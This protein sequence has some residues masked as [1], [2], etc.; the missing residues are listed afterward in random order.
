VIV[1]GTEPDGTPPRPS[2][3]IEAYREPVELDGD[4]HV[5]REALCLALRERAPLEV[6]GRRRYGA[7]SLATRSQDDPTVWHTC[8]THSH[9]QVAIAERVCTYARPRQDSDATVATTPKTA[10][11]ASL[12]RQL[13]PLPMLAIVEHVTTR[14]IWADGRWRGSPAGDYDSESRTITCLDEIGVSALEYL[15]EGERLAALPNDPIEGYRRVAET[16]LRELSRVCEGAD[17]LAPCDFGSWLTTTV[18]ASTRHQWASP[19]GSPS[20]MLLV[21]SPASGAGG[22]KSTL[23]HCVA[24]IAGSSATLSTEGVDPGEIQRQLGPILGDRVPVVV[25]DEIGSLRQNGCVDTYWHEILTA[26]SVSVRIVGTSTRATTENHTIFVATGIDP[27]YRGQTRR[28]VIAARL[29]GPARPQ[30]AAARHG[31]SPRAYCLAHAAKLWSACSLIVWA[32]KQAGHP[33]VECTDAR[34]S[35][36]DYDLVRRACV[37]A[38]APDCFA[39][40]I[41]EDLDDSDQVA[42]QQLLEQV[43]EALTERRA[44]L[45]TYRDLAP[46]VGLRAT[47]RGAAARF[48][49]EVRRSAWPEG[50]RVSQQRSSGRNGYQVER[51]SSAGVWTTWHP[52]DKPLALAEAPT[53]AANPAEPPATATTTTPLIHV[54]EAHEVTLSVGRG[55]EDKSTSDPTRARITLGQ[56]ARDLAEPAERKGAHYLTPGYRLDTEDREPYSRRELELEAADLIGLDYDA[57]TKI[58]PVEIVGALERAG[59]AYVA[60]TT[61]SHRPESPRIRVLLPLAEPVDAPTYRATWAEIAK[62]IE[63]ETGA[64]ADPAP[65]HMASVFYLGQRPGVEVGDHALA[66][67]WSLIARGRPVKPVCPPLAQPKPSSAPSRARDHVAPADRACRVAAYLERVPATQ[68]TPELYALVCRIGDLASSGDQVTEHVRRWAA[69]VSPYHSTGEVFSE[70]EID[71]LIGY[72]LRYRQNAIGGAL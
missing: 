33:D 40:P 67:A 2:P 62:W 17:W 60:A 25:C 22:G 44:S 5:T 10:V 36:E 6:I 58:Q 52:S 56:L 26:K 7:W 70:R 53:A 23:A 48:S 30:G 46:F 31:L 13:D 55:R 54:T 11:V 28:R 9:V 29:A 19:S 45:I 37:W 35:Y 42:G 21:R 51:L 57:L 72:A 68:S 64:K 15:L 12:I 38:G 34:P 49:S 43:Q 1:V 47:D 20:P 14:P 63:G 27:T 8:E 32:Y 4:L 65:S 59:L 41:E 3:K 69:R 24:L 66:P 61:Y 39:R 71:K 18:A 50:W 16:S